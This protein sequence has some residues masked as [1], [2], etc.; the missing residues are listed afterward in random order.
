MERSTRKAEPAGPNWH[1]IG[2]NGANARTWTQTSQSQQLKAYKSNIYICC[3]LVSTQTCPLVALH[4]TSLQKPIRNQES[5]VLR[6]DRSAHVTTTNAPLCLAGLRTRGG[7]DGRLIL[8]SF[9]SLLVL[10]ERTVAVLCLHSPALIR[11]VI[12]MEHATSPAAAAAPGCACST[13][14][15]TA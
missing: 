13:P 5:N 11:T 4:F 1:L 12:G 15:G 6:T 14:P 3:R 2:Q 9:F 10:N 8:F 7:L